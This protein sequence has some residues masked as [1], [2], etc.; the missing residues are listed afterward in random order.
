MTTIRRNDFF[1][2]FYAMMSSAFLSR[3]LHI[4]HVLQIRD[5]S[6]RVGLLEC[7]WKAVSG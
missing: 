1:F 3:Q 2:L 4:N 5:H 6:V 7:T